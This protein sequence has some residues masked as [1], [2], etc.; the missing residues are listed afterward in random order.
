MNKVTQ[1]GASPF[2]K[3]FVFMA[4][5]MLLSSCG[6]SKTQA[7]AE[8]LAQLQSLVES[9]NFSFEAEFALPQTSQAYVGAANATLARAGGNT[10][11]RISL[12]G[13]GYFLTMKGDSVEA[14][15]PY[16]G[17]RDNFSEY[18]RPDGIELDSEIE[19]LKHAKKNSGAYQIRFDARK[20]TERFQ[21]TL[22]MFAGGK[23]NL[24][25]YSG[26]RDAI[27][28]EGKTVPA[29]EME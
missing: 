5:A 4:L 7:T 11:S 23:A 26:Q 21:I 3:G 16:Y 2:L 18:G 13:E 9:R 25:I 15:L 24:L 20:K 17:V 14:Y 29:S 27:R 22:D 8:Q 12:V 28:Y 10:L 19:N 1:K 6:S